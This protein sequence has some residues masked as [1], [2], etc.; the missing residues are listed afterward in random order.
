MKYPIRSC[1]ALALALAV[2]LVQAERADRNKPM[3]IEADN[4]RHDDVRQLS[5]FSGNVVL[6]K[7]T[8]IIRAARI[9]VRQDAEG[10]QHGVAT[11]AAGQRAF[12][13]QK[14]DGGDEYIEGEAE[15]I[16][17]DGKAD[18][19]RFSKRAVMRRYVGTRVNDEATGNLIS[20][21][22]TT[23][24]Y[25][26]D[27]VPASAGGA[28]GSGRVR[29]MLTPRSAAAAPGAPGSPAATG[30]DAPPPANLRP[31]VTLGGDRK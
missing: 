5:V 14:R 31:S 25:R 6:T 12:F 15:T 21:D 4:L 23:E 26:V 1:V 10:N 18:Q 24:A 3:N 30:A 8:M 16:E 17:Y 27:G 19:V 22:N 2:T 13:R 9:E 29:A 20:F 7:G 28:P 11:A